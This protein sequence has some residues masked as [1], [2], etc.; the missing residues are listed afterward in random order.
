MGLEQ[1]A[2]VAQQS[3]IMRKNGAKVELID[4]IKRCSSRRRAR[5]PDASALTRRGLQ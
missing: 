5:R 4:N 2:S 1:H 3:Y